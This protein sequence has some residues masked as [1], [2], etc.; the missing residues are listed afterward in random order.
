MKLQI[1]SINIGDRNSHIVLEI[2]RKTLLE[3]KSQTKYEG[4]ICE[5]DNTYICDTNDILIVVSRGMV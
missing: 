5:D 1:S 2:L 3:I 4:V